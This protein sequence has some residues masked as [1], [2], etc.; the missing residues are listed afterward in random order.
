MIAAIIGIITAAFFWLLLF[1]INIINFWYGMVIAS[2]LLAIWSVFNAGRELRSLFHFKT[3][4]LYWGIFSAIFLY[5][6]FALGNYLS[7][8]IIP[9]AVTQVSDIYS[10]K[11]GTSPI[12][13]GL[14]LFFWIGPAEEVFWR[15]LVQRE[16]ARFIG[17]GRGWILAAVI[18]AA[19][20]LWSGNFILVM[21][22]LICG[23]FWGWI[24]KKTKSLWPGIISHSIWDIFAFLILPFGK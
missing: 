23:L 20:H 3:S 14:L 6:V 10:N 16:F 15:G 19:V 4:Y 7:K 1:G 2:G 21:A 13:I 5:T 11:L 8:I 24:Y 18:Y 17:G 9:G 22:A 12:T